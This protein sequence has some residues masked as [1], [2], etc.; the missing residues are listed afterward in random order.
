VTAHQKVV[1][2][3]VLQSRNRW[4]IMDE[5]LLDL[6]PAHR[7]K[8]RGF[9]VQLPRTERILVARGVR[10][11]IAKVSS[12]SRRVKGVTDN[13]RYIAS[14]VELQKELAQECYELTAIL[15]VS[16]K[17]LKANGVRGRAEIRNQR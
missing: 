6:A 9:Y 4:T 15:V 12:Y 17:T 11:A 16:I 8:G 10:Q 3:I 5:P 14:A 13:L 2:D 1:A 7:V